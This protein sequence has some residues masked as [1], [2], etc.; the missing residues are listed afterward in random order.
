[1]ALETATI[2]RPISAKA[3]KP[4]GGGMNITTPNTKA[5]QRNTRETVAG[6]IDHSCR[7]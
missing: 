4:A 3:M 2:Q 6:T 5:V 1:M 7:S